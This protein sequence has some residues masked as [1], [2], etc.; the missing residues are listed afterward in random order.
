MQDMISAAFAIAGAYWESSGASW[1]DEQEWVRKQIQE[2]GYAE[3][4]VDADEAPRPSR[5]AVAQ[6]LPR[7][8]VKHAV[9]LGVRKT[10]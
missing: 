3:Y 4:E 6:H 1:L 5:T 9:G 7:N 2:K 8:P 10:F